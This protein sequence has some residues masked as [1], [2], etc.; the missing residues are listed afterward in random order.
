[1]RAAAA[2]SSPDPPDPGEVAAR[3]AENGQDDGGAPRSGGPG[4]P[5]TRLEIERG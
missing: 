4:I 1:M 3:E 5:C 2:N